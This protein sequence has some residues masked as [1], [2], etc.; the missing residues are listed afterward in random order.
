MIYLL[1]PR[2]PRPSWLPA[3]CAH[4]SDAQA[5]RQAAPHIARSQVY[6]CGPDA[7]TEAARTAAQQAGTRTGRLHTEL[8]S[9]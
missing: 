3:R 1:G 7:W 9:W 5:L 6:I 2:A 4:L 8:F